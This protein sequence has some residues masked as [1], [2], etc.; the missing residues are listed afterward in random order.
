MPKDTSARRARRQRRP[1][2]V[3]LNATLEP[4]RAVFPRSGLGALLWA[5]S[6][7]ER[8]LQ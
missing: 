1:D 6:S 4:A 7:A 3:G 5:A 2:A 8:R